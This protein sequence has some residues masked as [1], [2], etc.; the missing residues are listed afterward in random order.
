MHELTL[1]HRVTRTQVY[2]ERLAAIIIRIL[3]LG[4]IVT[5]GL[6]VLNSATGLELDTSNIAPQMAAHLGPG[7]L[8]ATIAL[9]VGATTGAHRHAV[10]AGAALLVGGFLLHAVGNISD[11]TTW[12]HLISPV[13]RAYQNRPLTHGWDW[14]G[15]VW[16]YGAV[17]VLAVLG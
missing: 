7:I 3:I 8:C 16:V 10:A 12:M 9:A 13:S 11:D 14:A 17:A 4:V 6:L 2:A 1:A 5:A 15:L